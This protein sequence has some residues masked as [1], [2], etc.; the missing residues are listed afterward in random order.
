MKR[1][2]AVLA[3]IVGS[4]TATLVAA[5]PAAA[6]PS[7]RCNTASYSIVDFNGAT[8]TA[9]YIGSYWTFS[10]NIRVWHYTKQTSSGTYYMGAAGVRCNSSGE[11]LG[12]VDL[13]RETLTQ[14]DHP[15]CGTVSYTIGDDSYQYLGSR[16]N[17]GDKFRYWGQ[18]VQSGLVLFR[19]VSAVR[20]D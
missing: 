17:A 20:C 9:S 19:G 13:T 5:S 11:E 10:A 6:A 18:T 7:I 15:K 12:D 14:S 1:L 16:F 8:H 3:V 2:V 4:A